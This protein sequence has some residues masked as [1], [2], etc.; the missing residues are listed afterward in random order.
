MLHLMPRND[1]RACRPS[2]EGVLL[3]GVMLGLERLC[4]RT[5]SDGRGA[6]ETDCDRSIVDLIA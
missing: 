3:R 1:D 2:Q 5:P 6:V 4:T